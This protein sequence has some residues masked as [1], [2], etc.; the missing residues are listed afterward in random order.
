MGEIQQVTDMPVYQACRQLAIAVEGT[1]RSFGPDFRWLRIQCLR[2]SESVCANMAEG[3]YSQ[4]S[5]EYLQSLY[6]SR[7]EARETMAHVQYALDVGQMS[8]LQ[9]DQLFTAYRDALIQ[10]AHILRSI[11]RKL[12]LRGKSK[13]KPLML[14]EELQEYEVEY[15]APGPSDHTTI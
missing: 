7:R 14:K 2:S 1:T 6:R 11:E 15:A 10:L 4:Y 9:A 12:E 3:F 5:T 13:G 8:E